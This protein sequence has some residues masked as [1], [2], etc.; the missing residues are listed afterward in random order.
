MATNN[1][2]KAT[3]QIEE[4]RKNNR[5]CINSFLSNWHSLHILFSC[6]LLELW[7][8]VRAVLWGTRPIPWLLGRGVQF[9][10]RIMYSLMSSL[11]SIVKGFPSELFMP[12]AQ[13]LS[14]TLKWHTTFQNIAKPPFLTKWESRLQLRSGSAQLVANLGRPIRHVTLVDLRSS[15]IPR[16]AIGI[17]WATIRPFSLFATQ[18]YFRASFIRRKGT[19]KHTWK[20]L[21]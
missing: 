19:P 8:Q 15:F 11:I 7:P 16:M 13:G 3:N 5:V 1:R 20:I 12:K 14:D 6:R 17:W 21:M 18:S 2:D 10:Y 9:Y 4:F